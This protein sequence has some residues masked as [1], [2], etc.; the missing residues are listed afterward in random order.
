MILRLAG[1]LTGLLLPALLAA[2]SGRSLP[3]GEWRMH[4]PLS[5]CVAVAQ[6][7][8]LI[9]CASTG[10]LI[11]YD[12]SDYSVEV[13]GRHNGLSDIGI[14]W[15]D[16]HKGTKTL[17][18]GYTN[19]NIDLIR[20]GSITNFSDIKRSSSIQGSRAIQRSA[21]YEN[22]AYLACPF[23]IVVLDLKRLE[24]SSTLYPL[25]ENA[26]INDISIDGDTIYVATE[27]GLY[28][29]SL[30]NPA[31]P[32][33]VAWSRNDL[34][35]SRPASLVGA[36]NGEVFVSWKSP[37]YASDTLF[38]IQDNVA[39]VFKTGESI[40]DIR[41]SKDFFTV[42]TN[43]GV[44]LCDADKNCQIAFSYGEGSYTDPATAVYDEVTGNVLWIADRNRGFVKVAGFFTNDFLTPE[45]PASGKVFNLEHSGGKLWVATGAYSE[46]NSPVYNNDDLLS[47]DG[48][49][50][51]QYPQK[52]D[53][54]EVYD[55]VFVTVNP[56][57]PEQVF[58][59]SWG[60]GL[61]ET[62]SGT[63]KQLYNNH[64]STLSGLAQYPD[65]IRTGDAEFDKAG[66]LWVTNSLVSQPLSVLTP[67]GEWKRFSLT[68]AINNS[69]YGR[70][71]RD[72]SDQIWFIVQ[73]KGLAV[74]KHDE[75]EISSVRLLT[76]QPGQG[77]LS[78]NSV[79]SIAVD[80]EGYVWVGT[81]KGICVFYAPESV[82]EPASGNSD[83][84]KLIASRDGFNQYLLEGEE[85]TAILVDGGNRKWFGTRN[86]GLFLVSPDAS[87]QLAHFTKDNSPLLD[88]YINS[89]AMDPVTGE[90]FIGT[91]AGLCSYRTDATEGGRTFGEVYA[92]PNPVYPDYNGPIAIKGLVSNAN[93]KI[94]DVAGNLVY[95]TVANGGTATWNGRLY[96]GERASTGVYLVFCTNADGS[97]THVTKLLFIN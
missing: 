63:F 79:S 97:Q 19:G 21:F 32:Y 9:Y 20:E 33:Y 41:E 48:I 17:L 73:G 86:A 60:A 62:R 70:M 78:S 56:R 67:G 89:L 39:E 15:I 10:G 45:G 40:Y 90:L 57:D 42:S 13:L 94:T 91:S 77:A 64:N 83:A 66:N 81:T 29:A 23:G 2:Q 72:S 71:I 22:Q 65:D 74:V 95:N 88:N 75:T 28:S 49:N 84:Q 14:S 44:W 58:A 69:N 46:S 93:V 35:G 53:T 3:V 37:V 51:K 76:E 85:V 82:T 30:K 1:L 27:L 55:L 31:L 96:S 52:T 59:S 6:A 34:F 92:F 12:K 68:S 8:P 18:V 43:Q 25:S 5:H 36:F 80:K 50:W 4:R 11:R 24:I 16:Y 87:E 47:F 61:V 38:R 7:E 26:V 54:S